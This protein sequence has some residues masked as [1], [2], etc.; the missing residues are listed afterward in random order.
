MKW[1]IDGTIDE[2]QGCVERAR[3]IIESHEWKCS[4]TGTQA[5][6]VYEFVHAEI[7]EV[8]R[9]KLTTLPRDR[10]ELYGYAPAAPTDRWLVDFL[11]NNIAPDILGGPVLSILGLYAHQILNNLFELRADDLYRLALSG[12]EVDWGLT[13]HGL[14]D[15]E[16]F[17][18]AR[19]GLDEWRVKFHERR[20]KDFESILGLITDQVRFAELGLVKWEG[21]KPVR[22]PGFSREES[23]ET[24]EVAALESAHRQRAPRLSTSKKVALALHVSESEGISRTAAAASCR[25]TTGTMNEYETFAQTKK[26][27]SIF[28]SSPEEVVKFKQYL[29]RLQRPG[30]G[31][32]SE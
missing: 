16:S 8:G 28:R 25:T 1:E 13:E 26:Q 27:L 31:T 19:E 5:S 14:D 30:K 3:D 17:R 2:V 6:R 7:G 23:G 24:R 18:R 20:K 22:V 9:F 11:P 21:G 10:T 32:G 15:P 29:R 4:L 12:E